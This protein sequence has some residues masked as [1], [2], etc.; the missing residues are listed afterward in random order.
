[1]SNTNSQ[2]QSTLQFPKISWADMTEDEDQKIAAE[3]P[4]EVLQF[5][6]SSNPEYATPLV[7]V[8]NKKKQRQQNKKRQPKRSY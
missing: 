1:M 7:E 4:Q 2:S 8:V 5:T 6:D 3:T